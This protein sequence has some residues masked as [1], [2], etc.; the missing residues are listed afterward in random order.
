MRRY[1][2]STVGELHNLQNGSSMVI[3]EF[4]VTS[5]KLSGIQSLASIDF[6][7]AARYFDTGQSQHWLV[8]TPARVKADS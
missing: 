4:T 8:P 5:S 2:P 7:A 1:H 6:V 3:E